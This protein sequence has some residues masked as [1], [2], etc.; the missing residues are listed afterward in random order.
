MGDFEPCVRLRSGTVLRMLVPLAPLAKERSRKFVLPF[1]KQEGNDKSSA[2]ITD[3][4]APCG[5]G[6]VRFKMSHKEKMAKLI[7]NILSRQS[8]PRI[9]ESIDPL[10]AHLIRELAI[11]SLLLPAPAP[12]P[13]VSKA[14]GRSDSKEALSR[15]GATPGT[16][17]SRIDPSRVF[18]RSYQWDGVSWLLQLYRCGLGGILA[19][20]ECSNLLLWCTFSEECREIDEVTQSIYTPPPQSLYLY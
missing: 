3:L 2:A 5:R 15:P 4:T 14:S 9:T 7:E 10:D 18:V 8:L 12:Q 16:G 19:G 17:P 11:R 20:G 13:P 1:A 6:T